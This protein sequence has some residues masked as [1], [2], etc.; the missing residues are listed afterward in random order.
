MTTIPNNLT[1]SLLLMAV[2]AIVTTGAYLVVARS[3]QAE[4]AAASALDPEAGSHEEAILSD[5]VVSR[6]E[7][8]QVLDDYRQCGEALGYTPVV[9]PGEG[10]RP[11]T[12]NFG[13]PAE[14]GVSAEDLVH[15]AQADLAACRAKTLNN[16]TAAWQAQQPVPDTATV[17]QL[18]D[19]LTECVK[20]AGVPAI[21][22]VEGRPFS[23]VQYKR[24]NCRSHGSGGPDSR[25]S[26]MC[27]P[28][29]GRDWP[30]STATHRA[31]MTR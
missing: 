7:L 12:V 20:D 13:H 10:L 11:T 4:S 2:L 19:R 29:A 31:A 1:K 26:S 23:W 17:M 3:A 24:A 18:F 25:L 15:R 5:G 9:R 27:P 16:V 6:S 30:R 21:I 8:E 22:D 14:A 28:G